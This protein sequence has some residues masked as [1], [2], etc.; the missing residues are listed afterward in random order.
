MDLTIYLS[1]LLNHHKEVG[2]DGLGTFLKRKVPGRYDAAQRMF[3]PPASVL[4]FVP[5][6]Q[7]DKLLPGLLASERQLD[8]DSARKAV[9][10]FSRQVKEAV[11]TSGAYV[12]SGLGIL[13]MAGNEIV[14][15]A[16]A[17]AT[18]SE[19]YGLP[20][21]AET[22]FE[23]PAGDEVPSA[24]QDALQAA[25][26]S[27]ETD[28][29]VESIDVKTG[30]EAVTEG[31]DELPTEAAAEADEPETKPDTSAVTDQHDGK[32][33]AVPVATGSS[34]PTVNEI[35]ATA[36]PQE[37]NTATTAGDQELPKK[38]WV[39]D[40]VEPTEI[41]EPPAAP[42]VYTED[43]KGISTGMKILIGILI[44][45]AALAAA[46]FLKPEWFGLNRPAETTSE[47]SRPA[48]PPVTDSIPRDTVS[49]QK[50]TGAIKKPSASAPVKPKQ[51]TVKTVKSNGQPSYEV[52]ASA[53]QTEKKAAAF[54]QQM[55]QRGVKAHIVE[56]GGPMIHISIGSFK[57]Y[58]EAEQ[59]LPALRK[60][61]GSNGAYVH[62]KKPN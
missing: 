15:E 46:Y 55:K 34:M 51:D 38:A 53:W 60:K 29:V 3:V 48:L 43:R 1:S 52:I 19:F 41:T 2:V 35:P 23:T 57:S 31:N 9:G 26:N 12:L 7:E 40:K 33:E 30:E 50:D 56:I 11:H 58:A 5:E 28:P 22:V 32:D 47:M 6:L 17:D 8:Q 36:G 21:M 4:A 16:N 49:V 39:F 59:N 20:P 13:R 62:T 44:V 24:P 27:E 25:D 10:E 37:Q 54:I 61:S 45:L 14:F 18:A 42:P